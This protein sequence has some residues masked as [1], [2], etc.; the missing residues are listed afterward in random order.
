MATTNETVC[1]GDEKWAFAF[2]WSFWILKLQLASWVSKGWLIGFPSEISSYGLCDKPINKLLI[3]VVNLCWILKSW[4]SHQIPSNEMQNVSNWTSGEVVVGAVC[5][6]A[7]TINRQQDRRFTVR[8]VKYVLM[9]SFF[10]VPR[11]NT[12]VI[13]WRWDDLRKLRWGAA[14]FAT[15]KRGNEEMTM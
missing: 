7:R 6:V 11:K 12:C 10:L 15:Y 4:W 5:N 8:H 2:Y 14:A 9:A 3:A 13:Y 1:C